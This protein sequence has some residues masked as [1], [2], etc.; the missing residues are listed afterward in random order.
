[1]EVIEIYVMTRL[2]I[3]IRAYNKTTLTSNSVPKHKE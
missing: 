3:R 1:M 2:I